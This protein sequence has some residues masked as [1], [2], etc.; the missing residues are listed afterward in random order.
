MENRS[1]DIDRGNTL[2]GAARRRLRAAL[3]MPWA[4]PMVPLLPGWA[5]GAAGIIFGWMAAQRKSE[6]RALEAQ[7]PLSKTY[8][9]A[10]RKESAVVDTVYLGQAMP[11]EVYK[12]GL[13]AQ[14]LERG[15]LDHDARTDYDQ[16]ALGRMQPMFMNDSTLCKHIFVGGSPGNGKTELALSL[17]YQNIRRGGGFIYLDPKSD[18]KVFLAIAQMMKEFNRENDLYYFNPDRPAVSHSYNPIM[19]GLP[20]E[21]VSTAMKL[22]KKPSSGGDEFFYRQGLIAM[23]AAIICLKAQPG[24]P[25]FGFSDLAPLFSDLDLFI[26]LW[27][28]M[29]QENEADRMFVFE[30]LRTWMVE[31]RDGNWKKTDNRYQELMQ[32]IKTMCMNFCHSEYLNLLNSYNPDIEL[33][34]ILV[35]SKVLYIGF[36]ALA[37][38]DGSSTFGRLLMA[39]LARAIGD[40]YRS[41]TR[42]ALPCLVYLDEYGSSADEADSELMQMGRD[43]NIAFIAAVQGRGF[44]DD[45]GKG[46]TFTDKVMAT[47]G[48]HIYLRIQDEKTRKTAAAM[49][50]SNITKFATTGVSKNFGKSFKNYEVGL[51][52]TESHGTG[53][54]KGAKEM[55]EDLIQPEDFN[56]SRGDAIMIGEGGVYRLRLPLVEFKEKLQ[57]EKDAYIP[58]FDG[59]KVDGMDLMRKHMQREGERLS[60]MVE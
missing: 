33:K 59:T 5:Y 37:D 8:E 2:L 13:A 51:L 39:D 15:L 53:L 28:K 54:S 32:G 6:I 24:S 57:D 18:V 1:T 19:H 30:F 52:N 22:M 7:R 41:R 11:Y 58:R 46:T 35:N 9:F 4:A 20:R 25:P 27:N 21:T 43:A 55:R 49:A 50:G 45:V 44:L 48:T 38:K 34:N 16:Q 23:Q 26:T 42:P 12:D 40:I 47:T 29:P 31:D 17:A 10:E 56:L 3:N 36:S 60:R 14:R